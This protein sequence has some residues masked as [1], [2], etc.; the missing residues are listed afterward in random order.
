MKQARAGFFRQT[1][2][3]WA[4]AAAAPHV[5]AQTPPAAPAAPATATAPAMAPAAPAAPSVDQTSY[6]FGLKF[7]EQLHN[8]GITDQISVDAIARGI[9]DGL[10]GK[11]STP[12]DQQQIQ[13]YLRSVAA[14]ALAKNQAAAKDFLERNGHEKGV[15]TTASGLQYKVIAP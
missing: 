5:G 12:G 4:I 3:A 6:A 14:A 13:S 1:C 11:K 7:G 15:T 10:Q 2:I 8:L 9:T